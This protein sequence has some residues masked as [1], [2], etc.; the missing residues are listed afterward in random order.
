M[1]TYKDYGKLYVADV[2]VIGGGMSGLITALRAKE[3]N[4][5]LDILVVDKGTIGWSGQ[6]TKAGNG[7]RATA[8]NEMAIPL[9]MGYLVNAHTEFMND[10]EFLA[11]YLKVH[12]DNIEYINELGVKTS[13]NEDGSVNYFGEIFPH[14]LTAAS[15]EINVCRSLRATAL[16]RGIRLLSRTNVFELLTNDTGKVIGAIGFGMDHAECVIFQAKA[17]AMATQGCH[18]KKIGLEFMGYGTGVGAAYRAGAVMRNVE[19]S[20]QTDIV[21]KKNNTPIY[22]GFNLICNS[23]GENIKD[24]YCGPKPLMEVSTELVLGM[25]EEVKQGNGPIWCDLEHPDEVRKFVGG[26]D[27]G[28]DRM[29]L[30]KLAWEKHVFE[31]T[32]RSF[33]DVGLKPETTIKMVLQVEPIKVDT[34]YKTD[35]D[36]LW[37]PGKISTQGC[38]YFGWTRG[39]GVGNASTTAM[40]AG[41]SIAEYVRTAQ[42]YELNEAQVKAYKEKIYAPYHRE[43][44][45]HPKE[46][47]DRIERYIFQVD[48]LL[49]KSEQ[50]IH[51]VLRDIEEMKEIVPQLTAEDPHGLAKCLEAADSLLCLEMVFRAADMRKETRGQMYPHYRAD[52]PQHDDKNWLKWI[53][54][55]QGKDAEMELFTEDIPMWRYPI[56]PEGYEIPEGHTEEFYV[57]E[58]P[59]A[60]KMMEC[61]KM[62]ESMHM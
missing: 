49:A 30:D 18:F 1:K 39:D 33:G 53:N 35:V 16:K 34:E 10:Q 32:A 2:L 5:D 42:Q 22:G 56:P 55:R 57:P 45:H 20:T 13:Y 50:S 26:Q 37:A 7:I 19:F 54:I 17:I 25:L 4:P 15:I 59:L 8:K 11:E 47:F 58:N 46:I 40:M 23:K 31:K 6:A 3:K 60:A 51:E 29:N 61:K 9:A 52:Y 12:E 28:P 27:F 14:A 62:M 48:K 44:E 36:G 38:A 41:D 21:F 24:K 43:S